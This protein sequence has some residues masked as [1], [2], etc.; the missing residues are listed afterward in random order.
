MI[1]LVPT[2]ATVWKA[3]E[4]FLYPLPPQALPLT[5]IGLGALAVNFTCALM[6][7]RY[8]E[9]QGSLTKAA[10]LSARND[11]YANIAIILA[12]LL[13]VF[14]RSL[15]PD[16]IIGL[17]IAAMNMDAAREVFNAARAEHKVAR[18]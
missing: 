16:L 13:T 10:F 2:I 5:L 1:L 8:R 6:L 14:T 7:S 18:S 4:K 17:S 11:V 3:W 9:H 12:G 15:W